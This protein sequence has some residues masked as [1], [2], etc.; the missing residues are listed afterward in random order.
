MVYFATRKGS[1]I[2][3]MVCD[4]SA[5]IRNENDEGEMIMMIM[6]KRAGEQVDRDIM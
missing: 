2:E 5:K 3:M 1:H 4:E 6:M